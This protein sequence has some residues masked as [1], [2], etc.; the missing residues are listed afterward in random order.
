MNFE[1]INYNDYEV[2]TPYPKVTT[3]EKD[4]GIIP[5]LIYS[6]S[7]SKGEFTSLS[8]Y[9]YQS[10]IVKPNE[11]YIGLSRLLEQISIKEMQHL[12]ILSQILLS[13]G[14]NPKFCRYIDNNYNICSSWSSD[15]LK[16]I[17]DVKNFILYN[18]SL[19]KSAINE[20]NEIV[21]KSQNENISE[22]I[23]RIIE[24]EKSHLEIFNRILEILNNSNS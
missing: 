19:E 11:N 12:E 4:E 21:N 10:F 20:Y 23:S 5:D 7:G 9:I 14:I 18:I 22:I 13:Q 6:Y 8:Q 24:D 1:S 17:T 3:H 15:Y 2:K 16:Y